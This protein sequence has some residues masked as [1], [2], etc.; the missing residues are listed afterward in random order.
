MPIAC[1]LIPR[2]SLLTVLGERREL[3]GKA[4]A[5]AP[6]PGG[7]QVIGQTSGAAEAFGVRAGMALGEAL[8]RCPQLTLAEPDPEQAE[9]TWETTLGRLEG[10]GAGIESHCAGEAFFAAGGLRRLWGGSVEGVLVRAGGV[11]GGP[12]RLGAGPSRL[13]AY[14][15]ALAMPPRRVRRR[16]GPG[17][18]AVVRSGFVL[19]PDGAAQ[20]F[21]APL[22]VRLLSERL[23]SNWERATIPGLLERLGIRT[24]GELAALPD[25]AVADRFGEAGLVALAM[26]RGI[27][28]PL[29]PRE[30][31][32]DIAE[33]LEL[34]EAASGLELERVAELLVDRLLANPARRG[35]SIR[36][37][38][39]AAQLVS[40]GGW[41]VDVTLR[42]ASADRE[43]LRL[44]LTPK[45]TELPSP[46]AGLTLRALELGEAEGAQ[47]T[48]HDDSNERRRERL[49]EAVR[50]VRAAGGR[51]AVLRVLEL[52]PASR[53]PERRATLTPFPEGEGIA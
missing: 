31:R 21:L 43:R 49:G 29:C 27:E 50:Q 13:G 7:P 41:R 4:L 45:L 47:A 32:E 40:G 25:D 6:E 22:S 23:A 10:I 1:A 24:L 14:A 37:L 52:D 16:R 5:L 28:A 48:L 12:V 9:E 19:V 51:E 38:R 8:S 2:F 39:L 30:P 20:A 34:H 18:E 44:A 35:R 53:V 46:A 17:P 11:I 3:M 26:A 36:R 33:R 42:L 15:A